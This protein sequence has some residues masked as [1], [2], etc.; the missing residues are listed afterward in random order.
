MWEGTVWSQCSV[1]P[2]VAKDAAKPEEYHWPLSTHWL[3]NS[4]FSWNS[5]TYKYIFIYMYTIV[6]FLHTTGVWFSLSLGGVVNDVWSILVA[7]SRTC[8]YCTH[9]LLSRK[10][11][12][13]KCH[14]WL[15]LGK[16][17]QTF[18][19][20]LK[21]LVRHEK[22]RQYEPHGNSTHYFFLMFCSGE[23]A[24]RRKLA[25]ITVWKQE[26]QTG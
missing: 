4:V 18:H 14:T 13:A 11:S 8:K 1:G 25:E 12:L 17:S 23:T 9:F 16:R 2:K 3:V 24:E 20:Q 21:H 10:A 6:L 7:C 5:V 22:L 19:L 15:Q 26:G